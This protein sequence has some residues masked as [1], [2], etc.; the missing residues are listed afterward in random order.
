MSA[1][2][3]LTVPFVAIAAIALDASSGCSATRPVSTALEASAVL[4]DAS[5]QVIGAARFTQD[6]PGAVLLEVEVRGLAPGAHGIHIHTTGACGASGTT[7]FGA[8]GGHFNPLGK[9]HGL[10]HPNGAH[11]G[12]LPNITVKTD[13]AGQLGTT[14][15][16]ISIA[17]GLTSLFDAD[18]SAVVIHA[19]AD[20]QVTDP[21]GN[22][23]ARIACGVIE[24]Q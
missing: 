4:R 23:G 11:S 7:A 1:R 13:G 5:G 2:T 9:A 17:A 14:S 10:Q 21:S 12:D 20:D 24:R 3:L 19:G 16:R 6:D 18:G 22:S 15:D 8:A